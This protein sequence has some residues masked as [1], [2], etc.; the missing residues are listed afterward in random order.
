[1]APR[2]LRRALAGLLVTGT[3]AVTGGVGGAPAGAAVTT[4]VANAATITIPDSGNANPYPSAITA[5]GL[6]GAVTD[7]TVR[8]EIDH[9]CSKDLDILLVGPDG[10]RTVLLSDVG[11]T[12]L[13][14]PF[15]CNDLK[16][17]VIVS[18][19]GAP[20]GTD[21]PAGNPITVRPSDNDATGHEGDTWSGISGTPVANN[22]ATF[23]G[24]EPNGQWKL[25]V[26]DDAGFDSGSIK[27][28]S[29]T[30]TTGNGAPT[31]T[32]QAVD[33]HK[34]ET[35]AITLGGTDPDGDALTC[36][37]TLG[38]TG[39]GTVTGSGCAVEYTAPVR[40]AT[41]LDSFGFKVRD[42]QGVE[43]APGTVTVNVVNRNPVAST[44]TVSVPAGSSV[45]ITLG[46][47]DPDPGEALALT[48][49]PAGESEHGKGTITGTGCNITYKAKPGASGTDTIGFSVSDGFNGSATGTVTVTIGPASLAGCSAEDTAVQRYVCRVYLD[50]L[51]RPAD[52]DGKA[53]WVGRITG[54]EPRYA[55]LNSFS[56]TAEYR[57][58]VVRRTYTEILGRDAGAADRTY[59][60]E[61]L[62][63]K[64]PDVLRASL[65]GSAELLNRAG[66]IDGWAPALYQLV[67]RRPATPVEAL[68]ATT[69][70]TTGG[71]TRTAVA[72]A[73]LATPEAD[74][75]TVQA[76]Y[77]HYLRRTP[78]GS[79]ASYWVG[80]LLGGIFE[81][82]MVVEIVAAAEYFDQP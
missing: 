75:V 3:L 76:T 13:S 15:M 78:P 62:K 24:K 16:K 19:A 65:L 58:R 77:E 71:K 52:A 26:V 49:I 29:L 14:V 10:T 32:N 18:D 63:T 73:L 5:A 31:A 45:P 27:G 42:A 21:V 81:T 22:L 72:Q 61:Q 80:R 43:S 20:F 54:G 60:A 2:S 56:R 11:E 25:Y 36:L 70:A 48:C 66:G 69:L 8:M 67:L 51:G 38:A 74:T 39:K 55:I 82:R 41:G 9:S 64:N 44:P 30:I 57:V 7:L 53:Y 23:D 37:P 12:A 6:G 47:T 33:V 17:T 50:M 28:W 68:T 34:G 1:M 40:G 79:E 46:G 59:W 35:T 4:T